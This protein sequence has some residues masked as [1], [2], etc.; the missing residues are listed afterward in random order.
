VVLLSAR[1]G[2]ESYI[3]GMNAGADDY[4]VKPFG[5]LELIARVK[6]L[7]EMTRVRRE[8]EQ[9]VTNILESITDGF[10]VIDADWRLTYL[11]N[12]E[13]KRV[14]GEHSIHPDASMGKHYWDEVFPEGVTSTIAKELRR[15]MAERV[16]RQ[17]EPRNPQPA[18]QHHGA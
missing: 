11:L 10:Q 17:Y 6:A 3:E 13:A 9:R 7:L 4:I 12:S 2:E 14:L 15:A 5:A 1:V 8:S 16:S 18:H